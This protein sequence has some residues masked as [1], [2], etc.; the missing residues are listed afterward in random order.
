[1]EV[2]L[3]FVELLQSPRIRLKLELQYLIYFMLNYLIINA[4]TSAKQPLN[5]NKLLVWQFN[6]KKR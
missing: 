1:M 2:Q 4:L 3:N 5:E 6:R